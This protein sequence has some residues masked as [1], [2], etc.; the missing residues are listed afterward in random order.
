MRFRFE[1]DALE[2]LLGDSDAKTENKFVGGA[3]AWDPCAVNFSFVPLLHVPTGKEKGIRVHC[4]AGENRWKYGTFTNWCED[5]VSAQ[6]HAVAVLLPVAS[7]HLQHCLQ[8]IKHE[9][10][11]CREFWWPSF[12]VLV[13]FKV[14]CAAA[15]SV[16]QLRI[17]VKAGL[18]ISFFMQET[19]TKP[20]GQVRP[21][22]IMLFGLA[23][24]M[25]HAVTLACITYLEEALVHAQ[26]HFFPIIFNGR[27]LYDVMAERCG[28]SQNSG[29]Q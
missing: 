9:C 27:Q 6:L 23:C 14:R 4:A 11:T 21:G 28:T 25:S 12:P 17:T 24:C 22:I 7:S 29:K 15:Q 5:S 16:T 8:S 10:V 3:C 19:Q 2:V 18:S 1:D 20:E 13:Y 26:I